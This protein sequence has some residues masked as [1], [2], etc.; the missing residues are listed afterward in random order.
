[1]STESYQMM[2]YFHMSVNVCQG[3]TDAESKCDRPFALHVYGEMLLQWSTGYAWTLRDEPR[4]S[5]GRW[6][7]AE[8]KR[9]PVTRAPALITTQIFPN[10][11]IFKTSISEQW[12]IIRR[13][14]N[15]LRDTERAF[16]GPRSCPHPAVNRNDIR[17]R[18]SPVAYTV[19]G[20][21][22]KWL[23]FTHAFATVQSGDKI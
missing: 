6:W 22:G 21:E 2:S 1:M 14:G 13:L 7:G 18:H 10:G 15:V 19:S 8:V 12:S 20:S 17:A 4:F 16:A 5:G 9:R 3:F 11:T 23:Q